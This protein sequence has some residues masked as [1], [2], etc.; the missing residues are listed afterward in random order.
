[1]TIGPVFMRVN[2]VCDQHRELEL[3]ELQ[4]PPSGANACEFLL[5]VRDCPRSS[6]RRLF[7]IDGDQL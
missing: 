1:M 7:E 5:D 3:N 4:S 2:A 6:D